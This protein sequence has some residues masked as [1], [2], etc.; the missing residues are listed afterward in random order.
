ML[1][2]PR[3]VRSRA[4][5]LVRG[6][7]HQFSLGGLCGCCAGSFTVCVVA[8]SSNPLAGAVFTVDGVSCT[9]AAGGCCTIS[10]VPNGTYSYTIKYGGVTVLTGSRAFASGNTYTFDVGTPSGFVCCGPCPIPEN[11]TLTDANGTISFVYSGGLWSGCYTFDPGVQVITSLASGGACASPGLVGTL[12]TGMISVG[13]TGACVG[14]QFSVHQLWNHA[15][16]QLISGQLV[17]CGNWSGSAWQCAACSGANPTE[18]W[19]AG[20]CS[21][22]SAAAVTITAAWTSC[23]PFA[24]SQSFPSDAGG[25]LLPIAVPNPAAGTVSISA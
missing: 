4:W 2:L 3:R 24:W 13:Y 15:A 22:V 17:D 12:G 9:T 7:R 18:H 5:P 20:D 25:G 6:P 19:I 1:T 16:F 14:G 8:C 21:S 23:E 10:G 11:L